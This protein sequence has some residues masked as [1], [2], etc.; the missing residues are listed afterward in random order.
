[1][2]KL[3]PVI[4]A[5]QVFKT[6]GDGSRALKVLDGADLEVLPGE[7]VAIVGASGSVKAPC[8]IFWERWI[9]P[10]PARW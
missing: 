10:M 2:S 6:F 9:T 3:V 4:Q 5:R 7:M 8:C 1:M